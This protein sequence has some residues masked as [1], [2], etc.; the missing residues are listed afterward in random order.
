MDFLRMKQCCTLSSGRRKLK[1]N[2]TGSSSLFWVANRFYRFMPAI[3]YHEL[4]KLISIEQVLELAAFV[5]SDHS[6]SQ[7]RGPCPVHCGSSS[8]SRSFSANYAKNTFQCF[9]CGAMGNQ[10]DLW[11]AVTKLPVHEAALDLCARLGIDPPSIPH[12]RQE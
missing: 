3:D 6:G 1:L 10:L 5:A 7:V 2:S 9:K 4:R 12:R 8:K 11:M